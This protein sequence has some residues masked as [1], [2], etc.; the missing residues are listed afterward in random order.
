MFYRRQPP[1]TNKRSEK[2][3]NES[4]QKISENP[5]IQS[6]D[7]ISCACHTTAL[8]FKDTVQSIELFDNFKEKLNKTVNFFRS[9]TV[10]SIIKIVCPSFCPTR[11][12]NFTYITMFFINKS[13]IIYNFLMNHY[14]LVQKYLVTI[15]P[16]N[17]NFENF[18]FQDISALYWLLMPYKCFI[19]TVESDSFHVAYLFPIFE[20]FAL[21]LSQTAQKASELG[22]EAA[23]TYADSLISSIRYLQP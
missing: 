21:T 15:K 14:Y 16:M 9:K 1:C 7:W 18:I 13:E 17:I 11:W 6:I 2:E 20:N 8:A 10:T 23:I 4:I 19:N 22:N 12:T 3:E 5:Y